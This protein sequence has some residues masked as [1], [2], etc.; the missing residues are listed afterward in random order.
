MRTAANRFIRVLSSSFS[1]SLF[2]ICLQKAESPAS[3]ILSLSHHHAAVDVCVPF[4]IWCAAE[5]HLLKTR[6]CRFSDGAFLHQQLPPGARSRR[7]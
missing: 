7:R 4:P 6:T 1:S 3:G 2:E 5:G